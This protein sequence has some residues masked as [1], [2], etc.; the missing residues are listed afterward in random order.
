MV[1]FGK[2]LEMYFTNWPGKRKV[3]FWKDTCNPTMCIC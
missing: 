1:N 3:G 2:A